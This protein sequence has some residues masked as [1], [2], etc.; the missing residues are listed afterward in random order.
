MYG[1]IK[2]LVVF[3]FVFVFTNPSHANQTIPIELGGESY[4][5]KY[6]PSYFAN[7]LDIQLMDASNTDVN[8]IDIK[9]FRGEIIGHPDSLITLSK[10]DDTLKGLAFFYDKYYEITGSM[11]N[12]SDGEEPITA[13]QS[14][15]VAVSDMAQRMTR[16]MCPINTSAHHDMQM[17]AMATMSM[18]TNGSPPVAFAV[19]NVNLAA[20]VA[21]ALD[22]P[23]VSFHGGE[24]NAV[25]N[26]LQ[27]LDQADMFYRQAKPVNAAGGLGIALHNVSI[28]VF[29]NAL[30]F[31]VADI[32][33][34][35]S[36]LANGNQPEI[37]AMAYLL[38]IANPTNS[39]ALFGS[40][41]T[42][43]AVITGFDLDDPVIG[44]GVA[45]LSFVATSCSSLGVSLNE[46]W[47]IASAVIL[48]HEIGH[49]FGSCHDGDAA[50]A[51]CPTSSVGCPA[52]SPYIMAP[53]V[54]AAATQ[55]S[56]CSIANICSHINVQTC[57]KQPIDIE[58]LLQ[59]VVPPE[60]NALTQG[61]TSVRT[62]NVGNLTDVILTN[63]NILGALENLSDPNN[64]NAEYTVV[65][66]DGNACTIAANRQSYTCTIASIDAN[67]A[68]TFII[69]ETVTATGT[70][71]FM[72]T[73]QY[74]NIATEQRV[75]VEPQNSIVQLTH[76]VTTAVTPPAAPSNVQATSLS[77]GNIQ[78]SWTDS[79]NNEQA[80]IIERSEDGG[81]V[82][83]VIQ[84]NQAANTTSYI[85][86][87]VVEGQTYTYRVSASN[88]IGATA[89]ANTP[90]ATSSTG[91]SAAAGGGG[92][93]GGA[94]YLMT[95][96]L[97]LARTFTKFR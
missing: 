37:D 16:E 23:Y 8:E 11:Q 76:T 41:R 94:F 12:L 13:M 61:N 95:L 44:D 81:T 43:G 84:A 79:S 96:F 1:L 19:G 57:Y 80:F 88:S 27:A 59:S 18:N 67:N 32:V 83:N 75:D 24:T 60:A 3:V 93:G 62:F 49:N 5:L 54:S 31:N 40:I 87:N 33:D 63:V 56:A 21:L 77:N 10:V 70:G 34:P 17:T 55:F 82:F 39:N 26:A 42:V 69:I 73:T 2:Y 15:E 71:Q 78:V 28:R 50:S 72:S 46:G 9:F 64:A 4:Q 58:I 91:I 52:A 7:E 74:K 30:P 22:P 68:Q 51:F 89:A 97:L 14:T 66:L 20:D 6:W 45:G 65:T 48:A 29:S 53:F 92:G 90:S 35:N 47:G 36:S 85:D 86:T 25:V 38:L